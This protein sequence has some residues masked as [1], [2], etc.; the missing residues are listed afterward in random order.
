MGII[1]SFPVAREH[2]R[3]P[4]LKC[5][6]CLGTAHGLPPGARGLGSG[7][8]IADLSRAGWGLREARQGGWHGLLS[9]SRLAASWWDVPVLGAPQS[10]LLP[11]W[12]S[13]DVALGCHVP[14][15]S[16]G[17]LVPLCP[18]SKYNEGL[19]DLSICPQSVCQSPAALAPLL[20]GKQP[21]SSLGACPCLTSCLLSAEAIQWGLTSPW[22]PDLPPWASL[23]LLRAAWDGFLLGRW[24]TWADE[25]K[26]H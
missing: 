21:S 13:L 11:V 2:S 16:G 6:L 22:A 18:R 5:I 20:R 1:L 3:S 19:H 9:L 4:A 7:H 25:D 8:H 23:S 26:Q 15:V 10:G 24:E 17:H 14:P 12:A